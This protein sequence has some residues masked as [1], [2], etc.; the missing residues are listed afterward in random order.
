MHW[1]GAQGVTSAT[2]EVT[3]V[4]QEVTLGVTSVTSVTSYFKCI[5]A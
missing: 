2:Q 4:T 3:I 1:D 5:F